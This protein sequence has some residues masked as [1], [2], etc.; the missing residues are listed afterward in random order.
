M[1]K[2]LFLLFSALS[3]CGFGQGYPHPAAQYS[4][5]RYD[6]NRLLF[7]GDSNNFTTLFQQFDKLIFEG[8]GNIQLMH[9]GG[10]HVQADIFSARMRQNL[11]NFYPGNTGSRGLIFPFTTAGTNNPYNYTV[12][13][14]GK[15]ENC[16]ST[17]RG[18]S[19]TLGLTGLAVYTHD[20]VATLTIGLRQEVQPAYNFNL[21]RVFHPPFTPHN[22]IRLAGIDTS[23]YEIT[24]DTTLG[25][26]IIR[27]HHF[28]EAVTLEF[29]RLQPEQR[30]F[31]LLGIDLE[32]DD[33]GITYHA[34]GLNGA[35]TVSYLRCEVW[36]ENMQVI[37][38]DL[39]IFAIGINDAAGSSFDPSYFE[40]NYR[41]LVDMVKTANPD[42]AILFVTNNDSYKKY[43][44]KYYVNTHGKIVRESMLKLAAEYG[45]AVWDLFGIMGGESSMATWEAESLAK[46][47]KIHFTAA[48]YNL[49]G[50]LLFSAL[51]KSYENHL[52]QTY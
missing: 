45:A 52:N 39:V 10:S 27:L 28:L 44:R 13:A 50:D 21:I 23:A 30:E 46:K 32:N 5:V 6:Q 19:C 3:L 24:E 41:K 16:K 38:P 2:I 31:T 47:D 26:T 36:D 12:S 9:I 35:S 17:K 20:S 22:E 15:W 40:E 37:H 49:I 29:V 7:P 4:F 25:V 14:T 1:Q 33:P 8:E 51:V 34:I 42:C 48:G 18:F 43:K 11:S